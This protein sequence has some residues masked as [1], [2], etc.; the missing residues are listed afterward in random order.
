MV[1]RMLLVDLTRLRRS[2]E[3]DAAA[4][5]NGEGRKARRWRWPPP[6]A[7]NVN[8]RGFPPLPVP[9]CSSVDLSAATEPR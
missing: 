4:A 1:V 2:G 6:T 7:A 3:I 9:R 8:E 5:W